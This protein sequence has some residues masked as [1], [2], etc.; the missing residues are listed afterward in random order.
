MALVGS[1]AGD[2]EALLYKMNGSQAREV[3]SIWTKK[4]VIIIGISCPPFLDSRTL[5][6][7]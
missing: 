3:C 6:F 1:P 2:S 5:H 4:Y 7:G